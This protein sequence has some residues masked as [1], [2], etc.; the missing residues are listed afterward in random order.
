LRLAGTS[1]LVTGATGGIGGAI[2]RE[3]DA[4]SCAVVVTGRR[5]ALLNELVADLGPSARG[6]AADLAD[7]AEV[8]RLLESAGP[9]DVIVANAGVEIAAPLQGLNGEQV[10]RALRVNLLAP[11]ELVR[12]VLPVMI[13]R[14]RGHIVFISSVAGL[15]ATP[16]NGPVYTATKWGLRGLGLALGQELHGTGVRVSTVFPGPIRD[17]GMFAR[18]NVKL[19]RHAGT[20]SPLDVARAVADAIERNRAEVTVARGSVRVSAALGSLAPRLVGDLARR[21]GAGQV[22]REMLAS[23]RR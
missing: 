22:R 21:L 16:G 5:V 12:A 18:T 17:A 3:L 19:P 6:I 11:L 4:R 8:E 15:V 9:L 7:P 2:A 14:G 23:G 20:N 13:E 1:A 10:E